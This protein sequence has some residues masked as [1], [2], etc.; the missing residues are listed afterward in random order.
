ME[1]RSTRN[2]DRHGQEPEKEG[3][4][5]RTVLGWLVGIINVGVATAIIG[6]TLGFIAA[7]LTRKRPPGIW[8]PVLEENELAD[9]ETKSVSFQLQVQDGYMTSERKYSAYIYRKGSKVVAYD[10]S[11]PHLGCHV[12]F[13]DRK[14]RYVCPCHGGVFDEEGERISGPPPRGLTK[15]A[16]KVDKGRIWVY[17]V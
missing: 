15:L 13:K 5:R 17:K 9:G 11:C 6:P 4:P 16:A 10:P 12:E 1:D 7:P 3:V 8:V 2:G 14:K